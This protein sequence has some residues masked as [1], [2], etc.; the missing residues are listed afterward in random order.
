MK[1]WAFREP[2]QW[3]IPTYSAYQGPIY[4]NK[5]GSG[6]FLSYICIYE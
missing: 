4:P 3:C 6:L 5:G 2:A 1:L